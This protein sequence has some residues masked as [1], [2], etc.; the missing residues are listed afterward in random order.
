MLSPRT[1]SAA[2]PQPPVYLSITA[3]AAKAGKQLLSKNI[4]T[5]PSK[6]FGSFF[7]RHELLTGWQ[8]PCSL[9]INDRCVFL[10]FWFGSGCAVGTARRRSGSTC[11]RSSRA[12]RTCTWLRVAP[13]HADMHTS[14]SRFPHVCR[15]SLVLTRHQHVIIGVLLGRADT[16]T[17]STASI[18]SSRFPPRLPYKPCAH[19][20]SLCNCWC[21]GTASRSQ[22]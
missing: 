4:E 19:A 14:A 17:V 22:G 10:Y 16:L 6:R 12:A 1:H 3:V 18:L 5:S 9:F 13:S 11:A 20:S 8:L 21:A 7:K 2:G 15:T